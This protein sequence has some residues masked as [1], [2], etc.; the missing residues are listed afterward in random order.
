MDREMD[1][2]MDEGT[3]RATHRRTP[4]FQKKTVDPFSKQGITDTLKNHFAGRNTVHFKRIVGQGKFGV[5]ALLEDT[6]QNPP[7]RFIIKRALG[8]GAVADLRKE[9]GALR[10]FRGSA[11]IIQMVDYRDQNNLEDNRTSSPLGGLAGPSIV[12]EFL[13]NGSLWAI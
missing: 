6:R 9:I 3:G 10:N 13:E 8:A 7:K 1:K 5:T 11:H 2:G 12:T 4:W